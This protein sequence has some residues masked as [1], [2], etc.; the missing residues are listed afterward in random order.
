MTVLRLVETC[1]NLLGDCVGLGY[2][3]HGGWNGLLVR[4]YFS[5]LANA[6]SSLA[7]R[8]LGLVTSN[9]ARSALTTVWC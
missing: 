4:D 2:Y 9:V 6:L 5:T 1:W 8:L 3:G 7:I